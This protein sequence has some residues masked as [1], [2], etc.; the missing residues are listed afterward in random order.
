M[1]AWPQ[2]AA[3]CGGEHPHGRAPE[4]QQQRTTGEQ[5]EKKEKTGIQMKTQN[6]NEEGYQKYPEEQRGQKVA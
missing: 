1:T 5:T 2:R 6:T 3:S 4:V